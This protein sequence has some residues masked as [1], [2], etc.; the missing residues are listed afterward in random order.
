MLIGTDRRVKD[1][2]KV[3]SLRNFKGKK[4]ASLKLTEVLTVDNN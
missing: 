4:S 3:F 2:S 1:D